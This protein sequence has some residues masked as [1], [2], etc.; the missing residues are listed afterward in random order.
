MNAKKKNIVNAV[1]NNIG[2]ITILILCLTMIS[3]TYFFQSVI[4]E[5]IS[6]SAST[7]YFSEDP[8]RSVYVCNRIIILRK[9]WMSVGLRTQEAVCIFWLVWLFI[10]LQDVARIAYDINEEAIN[11]MVP[12]FV[13]NDEFK[14]NIFPDE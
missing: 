12:I 10:E 8:P 14:N 11:G 3:C 2:I 5:G 1:N 6:G 13:K 9:D 4:P 7:V